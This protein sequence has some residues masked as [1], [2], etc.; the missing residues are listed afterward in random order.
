MGDGLL[1][2]RDNLW[3]LAALV[4]PVNAAASFPRSLEPLVIFLNSDIVGGVGGWAESTVPRVPP[5][6]PLG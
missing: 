5:G 6:E 1:Q 3:K 2:V 4:V